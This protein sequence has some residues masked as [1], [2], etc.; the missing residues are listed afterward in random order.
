MLDVDLDGAG[1]KL[2]DLA[3]NI[4]RWVELNGQRPEAPDFALPAPR[5]AGLS[6][7]KTDRAAFGSA[8]ASSASPTSMAGSKRATRTARC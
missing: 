5:S 7:V 1:L 8:N 4:V 6:M 3:D 2:M